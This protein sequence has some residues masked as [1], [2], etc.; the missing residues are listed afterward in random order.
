MPTFDP[1]VPPELK[2]V[3]SWFGQVISTPLGP[4]YTI[5]KFG[6]NKCP[7]A[8]E[9]ARFVVKSPTLKPEERVEIYNQQYWY[10]LINTLQDFFPL[11]VRLFGYSDFNES[12]AIPYLREHRPHHWS[13]N[14]LGDHLPDWIQSHYKLEDRQLVF[15]A[16]K[17][18]QAFHNIFFVKK[19]DPPANLTEE[20]LEKTLILQP[21]VSMHSLP[22]NLFAFRKE[23]LLNTPEHWIDNPFP[24]LA[25]GDF[26]FSLF[27]NR[28]SSIIWKEISEAEMI[29]LKELQKGRTLD[30]LCDFLE[31]QDDEIKNAAEDSLESWFKE[32]TLHGL[33]TT[34]ET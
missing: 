33:I 15:D 22:Y 2:R 29:L 3:Q 9:A 17:L 12:I 26:R 34:K 19:M 23:L 31:C 20:F 4:E 30:E 24:E 1:H 6:P 28:F 8:K 13:L 11:L 32:W 16:A 5:A 14:V 18:D 27:R 7:I 10:R 25:K 21:H